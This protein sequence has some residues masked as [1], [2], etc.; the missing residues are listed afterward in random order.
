MPT[1]TV[2]NQ[3]GMC[4][5]RHPRADFLQVQV[6]R[7]GIGGR[8]DQSGSGI[9]AGT[10]RTENISPFVTLVAWRRRAAAPLG[11]KVSQAALL[12]DPRLVLP[13]ELEGPVAGPIGNDLRNKVVEVLALIPTTSRTDSCD[14][15]MLTRT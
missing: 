3:H 14:L 9:A 12:T 13:P 6:H 4:P 1:G 10:D 5:W 7:V 8:Q 15:A 2:Q 11:P